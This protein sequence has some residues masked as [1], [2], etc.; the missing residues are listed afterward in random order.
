MTLPDKE[1]LPARNPRWAIDRLPPPASVEARSRGCTCGF[2]GESVYSYHDI[3]A[4]ILEHIAKDTY[5]SLCPIH[6][7][8]P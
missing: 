3:E 7:A 4:I 2:K 1:L 5:S 6:G 8:T